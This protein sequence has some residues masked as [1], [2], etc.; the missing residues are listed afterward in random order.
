MVGPCADPPVPRSALVADG[1]GR[2]VDPVAACVLLEPSGLPDLLEPGVPEVPVDVCAPGVV[3]PSPLTLGEW[4]VPFPEPPPPDPPADPAGAPATG[5]GTAV[6]AGGAVDGVDAGG[7][8]VVVVVEVL[9]RNA[10][11]VVVGGLLADA[12]PNS[13]YSTLPATGVSAVAPSSE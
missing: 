11:G 5:T 4:L 1:D 3:V 9:D 6:E 13:Q 7:A 8:V 10:A 12:P 2:V